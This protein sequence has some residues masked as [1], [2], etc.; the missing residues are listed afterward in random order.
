[1]RLSPYLYNLTFSCSEHQDYIHQGA[2][3]NVYEGFGCTDDPQASI[4]EILTLEI[5]T[6]LPPLISVV[7]YYRTPHNKPG[8]LNLRGL[9]SLARVARIFYRQ[10]RD[11]NDFLRSNS[12][13]SR[14]NYFRL[15]ALASIDTLLTL[16][17]GIVTTRQMTP[18]LFL[19]RFYQTQVWST[20]KVGFAGLA[21]N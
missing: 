13:V 3:F 11:V 4:F 19:V 7:F 8:L 10:N 20:K 14:I 15:L 12:S 6:I 1:M 16:P 17:L 18:A 9:I 2:R 5:W 21:T